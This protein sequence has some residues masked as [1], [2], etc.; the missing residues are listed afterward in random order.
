[1]KRTILLFSTL[2]FSVVILC[3]QTSEKGYPNRTG[4]TN[5][6]FFTKSDLVVESS[7]I[8]LVATYDIEGNKRLDDIYSIAAIKIHKVYKGDKSLEGD[9]VYIVGKASALGIENTYWRD[10]YWR[11]HIA[12][13]KEGEIAIEPIEEILYAFPSILKHNDCRNCYFHDDAPHIHFF[14]LSDFPDIQN[15]KIS[16]YIK[17]KFLYSSET[18]LYV[19]DDKILGLNN[20][21]FQNRGEFY[22][23]IKQFEGF[24]VPERTSLPEEQFE[25]AVPKEIVIDSMQY[26]IQKYNETPMDFIHPEMMKEKKKEIK[27]KVRKKL[28]NSKQDNNITF[29]ID[30]HHF[31]YDY[32]SQKYYVKF[33]VLVVQRSFTQYQLSYFFYLRTRKASCL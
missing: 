26:E 33:D 1:M 23:Y 3:A 27:K 7:Y 25:K 17:Y 18:K 29:Q 10:T 4:L 14:R 5:E 6:D 22:D 28:K 16:P 32:D 15:P 12:N 2:L 11:D 21:V 24:I 13:L 9:T 20:L 31:I 30:N 8:G 19:C